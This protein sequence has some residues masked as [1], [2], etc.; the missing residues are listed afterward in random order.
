[1]RK[2]ENNQSNT[3]GLNANYDSF[4]S[5]N[6]FDAKKLW[7]IIIVVMGIALIIYAYLM[8]EKYQKENEML[9]NDMKQFKSNEVVTD[10]PINPVNQE[11]VTA[12]VYHADD[13]RKVVI[14][15]PI[16]V[17]EKQALTSFASTNKTV[18][19][20]LPKKTTK[21]DV[22]DAEFLLQNALI[23]K[24]NQAKA[25]NSKKAIANKPKVKTK[26]NK[27]LTIKQTRQL[28]NT[29]QLQIDSENTPEV[30]K[31]LSQ[32]AKSSG[33]NSLVYLRMN[34]YWSTKINNDEMAANMYKKI[35]F[36]NPKDIQANTNLALL[37]A[38]NNQIE[39]AISRL[40]RLK[41][42]NPTNKN[43]VTY[44][45]RVESMQNE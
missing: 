7:M 36:Q 32:L 37:E 15:P 42:Q 28:V 23:K 6:G 9:L 45:N 35:L 33:E 22:T 5:N 1:M 13:T 3:E 40:T 30:E 21:D 18:E 26:K 17:L 43:I 27:K 20:N 41:Q 38:K 4:E 10:T 14:Q 44:L 16:Q 11:K 34:A 39:Q 8:L 2:L 25:E 19:S 29:L 12:D 24:Q 31:L